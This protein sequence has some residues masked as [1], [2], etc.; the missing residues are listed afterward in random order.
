[1]KIVST[2][3]LEEELEQ[4]KARFLDASRRAAGAIQQD[5]KI[6]NW[7]RQYPMESALAIIG[8]GFFAGYVIQ[9]KRS[10]HEHGK[11]GKHDPIP[12]RSP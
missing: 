10:S 1:M 5:L 11:H 7:F 9:Q 4:E 2:K 6:S 3:K 8:I 12:P